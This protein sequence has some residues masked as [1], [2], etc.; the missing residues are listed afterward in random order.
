MRR[1]AVDLRRALAVECLESIQNAADQARC[2][3]A[4]IVGQ[5]TAAFEALPW[6]WS[7]Q[8]PLKLQ[9]AGLPVPGCS[10]ILRGDPNSSVCSV[11]LF[12][13]DMLVCVETLNRAADH[14]LAR[15]LLS[16]RVAVTPQ[17]A[18][19]LQFDLKSLI[20]KP[21]AAAS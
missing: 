20:P 15:R 18:G 7:T 2:V 5:Q 16:N 11:F 8:G 17:Q 4:R 19:D 12:R 10:E 9:M 1:N 6:F 13:D 21:A 14:M 3:A